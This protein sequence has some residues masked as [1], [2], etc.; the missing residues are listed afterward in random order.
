MNSDKNDCYIPIA[1][2]PPY[3]E[4]PRTV[5]TQVQTGNAY[6]Y[7]K[8]NLQKLPYSFTDPYKSSAA[9]T[10]LYIPDYDDLV[11]SLCK[12]K[13]STTMT[14]TMAGEL[15]WDTLLPAEQHQKRK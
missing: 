11:Y 9:L 6:Q 5:N 12:L 8:H 14:T 7:Q 4:Y 1:R 13:N 3:L 10:S 15:G 2:V